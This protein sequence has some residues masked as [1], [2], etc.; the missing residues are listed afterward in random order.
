MLVKSEDEQGPSGKCVCTL[1]SN[2]RF[3][4]SA[5]DPNSTIT[6]IF[7]LQ[8]SKKVHTDVKYLA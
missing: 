4:C 1:S 6:I 5:L 3:V 2:E 7:I 8:M